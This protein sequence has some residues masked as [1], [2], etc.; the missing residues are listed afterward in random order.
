[1][2]ENPDEEILLYDFSVKVG[3]NV[4]LGY[5]YVIINSIDSV[6]IGNSYRK[7]FYAEFDQYVEGIGGMM[8]GLLSPLFQMT[9][10]GGGS[11]Q[12]LICFS[13]HGETIY[14]NPRYV[15]CHSEQIRSPKS[16]YSKI[17][18]ETEK[19]GKD[20]LEIGYDENATKD[21]DYIFGERSF[22]HQ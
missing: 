15:D 14:L 1:M 18:I 10:C 17:Y 21:V 8:H 22:Q 5:N 4:T 13:E 3:D 11:S 19:G 7:R 2:S 9:T 6:K 20:F 16:F 12:E